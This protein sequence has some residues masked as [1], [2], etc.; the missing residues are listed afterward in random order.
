VKRAG[1][2]NSRL[3]P[4]TWFEAVGWNYDEHFNHRFFEL[5]ERYLREL[6]TM[7]WK[8]AWP[9]AMAEWSGSEL[10]WRRL[11]SHLGVKD[12]Y[13]VD[14]YLAEPRNFIPATRR[15]LR[16]LL[17][18]NVNPGTTTIVMHNA[19]EPFNPYRSL[20]L[21]E[22]ARCIVVDRDPR[23]NF[24]A[25]LQYKSLALPAAEF[26]KRYRAHRLIAEGN[27]RPSD[28]VLR[29]QYEDLVL[30]YEETL[31]RI[32]EFLGED[33]SVHVKPR[34]FF[35]PA[36][37]AKNI[38]IWRNHPEPADIELIV[39]ELPQHCYRSMPGGA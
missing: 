36:I 14:M 17:S 35:N 12:A 2:K 4:R 32:L 7:S 27:R 33:R 23:D 20:D 24:V 34:Q 38:G 3:D 28:R 31:P 19:F 22:S 13:E 10:F 37:S 15:Y 9:Y 29:L 16:D 11:I 26:A 18:S 39:R 8:A 25:M 5:S 30:R 21:F 6:V 1:T